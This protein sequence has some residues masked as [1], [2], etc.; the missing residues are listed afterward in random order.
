M[1]KTKTTP[2][3][4][5]ED[6]AAPVAPKRR[7]KKKAPPS[8]SGT[9]AIIGRPNVGKSTLLNILVKFRLSAISPRPQTTRHKI[10]G[11][12][13][14]EG[15]QIAFLDTPGVPYKTSHALDRLLVMRSLD[16][17]L[18]ADLAVLVVEPKL[19]ADIERRLI[20]ELQRL[21]KPSILA[22][23]KIDVVKKAE[24]LPIMQEY[25]RLYPFLEIFPLSALQLDDVEALLDMVVK[26][27]PEGPPLF[28]PDELTDRPERFL[29]GEMIREQV[30]NVCKQEVP[31]AVAVE[32]D[33]FEEQSA[34]YRGKDYIRAVLYVEKDSQKAIL[35]GRSGEMLKKIGAQARQEIETLLGRPV[36]LE[37]WVK[38]YPKWRKDKAFLQRIGY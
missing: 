20:D 37:T 33:T 23:N 34:E 9:V 21:N 25:S 10:L 8:K 24:L 1:K 22:I 14:G 5:K 35:I 13:T 4:S 15:Y 31:Y 16:A 38:V 3:A 2:G 29:A 17:V 11:V 7:R 12:L 18:E 32:I 30:F 27:L 26:H 6:V 36:Y 19:P 28:E